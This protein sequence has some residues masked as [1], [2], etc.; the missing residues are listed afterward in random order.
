MNQKNISIRLLLVQLF[1]LVLNLFIFSSRMRFLPWFVED[2]VGLLGIFVTT[3]L[4]LF[5]GAIMTYLKKRK[6]H[7]IARTRQ[8]IPFIASIFSICIITIQF[9]DVVNI[10]ALIFTSVMVVITIIF[11]L[12]DFFSFNKNEN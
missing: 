8:M 11:V 4:L 1:V 5:I 7:C 12:Q 6:G 3:P 9:T 10:I 2:S